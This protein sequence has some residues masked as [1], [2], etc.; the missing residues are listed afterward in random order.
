MHLGLLMACLSFADDAAEALE[1]LGDIVLFS[2]VE[3]M[4]E[5]FAETPGEYVANA[6]QRF[7]SLASD[8]DWLGLMAAM[9]RSDD[10]ARA[11]LKQMLQW[12]LKADTAD[13]AS[14][15]YAGC[16]CGGSAFD[17]NSA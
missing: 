2:K 14:P 17:G 3:A 9:E 15:P 7:A 1:A 5:R 4:G 10:P 6:A 13:L 8:E 12:A 11:A 16:T